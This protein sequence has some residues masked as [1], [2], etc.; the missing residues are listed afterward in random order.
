MLLHPRFEL[1]P[2]N[3]TFEVADALLRPVSLLANFCHRV[4]GSGGERLGSGRE[5]S[6]ARFDEGASLA[7][8]EFNCFGHC[9]HLFQARDVR[10]S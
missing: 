9:K 8:R 2:G 3:L 6:E 10:R 4:R 5:I 7:F 1:M